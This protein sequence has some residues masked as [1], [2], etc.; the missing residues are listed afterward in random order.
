MTFII[1]QDILWGTCMAVFTLNRRKYH[2]N[3]T[4]LIIHIDKRLRIRLFECG[5][6]YIMKERSMLAG[7]GY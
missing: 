7:H 5:S 3:W 2:R 1:K 4:I 6:V